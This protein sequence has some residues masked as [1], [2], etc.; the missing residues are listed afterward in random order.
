MHQQLQLLHHSWILAKSLLQDAVTEGLFTGLQ[1]TA[2]RVESSGQATNPHQHKH[3]ADTYI[4]HRRGP[5]T[6]PCGL[7]DCGTPQMIGNHSHVA[8]SEE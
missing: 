3:F 4:M 1:P 6:L 5:T 8:Q 7:W 2:S